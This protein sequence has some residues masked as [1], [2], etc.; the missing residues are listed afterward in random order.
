[1]AQP[2]DTAEFV[3]T[4][5]QV[6][7]ADLVKSDGRTATATITAVTT[8]HVELPLPVTIACGLS[9]GDKPEQIVQRGTELGASAFVFFD[10]QWQRQFNMGR[11]NGRDCRCGISSNEFGLESSCQRCSRGCQ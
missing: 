9:K 6:V 2:G 3:T 7:L 8:P 11:R 1:R 4:T 10:S 5:H